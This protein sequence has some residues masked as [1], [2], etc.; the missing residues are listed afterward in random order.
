MEFRPRDSYPP[1]SDM[2]GGGPFRLSPGQWTDD[3]AMALALADTLAQATNFDEQDLLARFTDWWLNG[4]YSCTGTCFDI[5]ITTQQALRKWLAEKAAHCG[6]TDPDTAG[7][8]SLMRLAPV[9]IRY[10]NDPVR[11]NDVASRQSKTTHAAPEAVSACV[12]YCE[13]IAD[14]INGMPKEEVL[15]PRSGD[16]AGQIKSIMSGQW[17]RKSRE[18]IKSSGYVAHSLEASLWCVDQTENFGDAVLLAANL[19]HDAD[20]TAA[21]T[22]QLAGALYGADGIPQNWLERLAWRDKIEEK[23]AILFRIATTES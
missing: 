10:F 11:L 17:R 18:E 8:G 4:T 20:T 13:L 5:G 15:K 14:A 12:A 23:A 2:V 21:I 19:G 16:Y 1:L 6:S 22:G 3:T 9:P 7:N